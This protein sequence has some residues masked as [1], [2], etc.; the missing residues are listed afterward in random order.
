MLIKRLHKDRLAED[1]CLLLGTCILRLMFFTQMNPVVR[2]LGR[3]FIFSV[4]D[5]FFDSYGKSLNLLLN[6]PNH[7][8]SNHVIDLLVNETI[9]KF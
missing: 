1:L 4:F 5:C 7:Q 6:N 8:A 9:E 3:C 2:T